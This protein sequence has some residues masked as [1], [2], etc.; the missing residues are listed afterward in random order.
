MRPPAPGPHGVERRVRGSSG[1][2][3]RPAS[4]N[5]FKSLGVCVVAGLARLNPAQ[6]QWCREVLRCGRGAFNEA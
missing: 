4:P 6:C 1:A 2:G 3:G 5:W